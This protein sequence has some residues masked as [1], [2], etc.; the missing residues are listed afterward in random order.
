MIII[1]C[2][3]L[4]FTEDFWWKAAYKYGMHFWPFRFFNDVKKGSVDDVD[5]PSKQNFALQK[6]LYDID[7]NVKID[8]N[9]HKIGIY[10]R[11]QF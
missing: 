10:R 5:I 9:F 3:I 2:L 4:A 6:K 7:C 11:P 8:S 1:A